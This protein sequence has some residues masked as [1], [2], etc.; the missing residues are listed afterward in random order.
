MEKGK[1]ESNA[2]TFLV[3]MMYQLALFV[4]KMSM[5]AAKPIRALSLATLDSGLMKIAPGYSL[6]G[7]LK[8]SV[9]V[10]ASL[11]YFSIWFDGAS[12]VDNALEA[13]TVKDTVKQMEIPIYFL[14]NLNSATGLQ[15]LTA[16]DSGTTKSIIIDQVS[17]AYHIAYE[18]RSH[19]ILAGTFNPAKMR[20]ELGINKIKTLEMYSRSK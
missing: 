5:I 16:I 11:T 3:N 17:S 15:Y 20:E 9:P 12:G 18:D 4:P 1:I 14:K 13:F 2:L 19:D 8:I 6:G 10:S 7:I